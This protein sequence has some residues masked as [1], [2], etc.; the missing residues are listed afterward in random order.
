MARVAE[1]VSRAKKDTE[2]VVYAQM[3]V[4]HFLQQD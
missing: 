2:A 1:Q 3:Q 4:K